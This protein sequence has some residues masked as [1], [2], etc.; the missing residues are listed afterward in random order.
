MWP[1]ASA[2]IQDVGIGATGFFKGV[3]KNGKV[4]KAPFVVNR[5]GQSNHARRQQDLVNRHTAEWIAEDLS[6]QA[7]LGKKF[8]GLGAECGCAGLG[9]P[10]GISCGYRRVRRRSVP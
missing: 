8:F 5:L 1:F 9:A 4:S 2:V 6:D 10:S 7:R 3:R